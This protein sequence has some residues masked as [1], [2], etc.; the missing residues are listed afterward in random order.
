MQKLS[1]PEHVVDAC[2][3]RAEKSEG[4]MQLDCVLAIADKA[5]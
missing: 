4:L 1:D 2:C 3:D 5:A